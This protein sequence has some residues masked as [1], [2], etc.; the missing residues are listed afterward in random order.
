MLPVAR[1][2]HSVL[3]RSPRLQALRIRQGHKAA[4]FEPAGRA[5]TQDS[6]IASPTSTSVS[7]PPA[8]LRA[9]SNDARGLHWRAPPPK[10]APAITSS[11]K[12]YNLLNLIPFLFYS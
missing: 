7:L 8:S 4:T 12:L 10:S 3:Y 1:R 6:T 5:L 9:C 11:L 2:L